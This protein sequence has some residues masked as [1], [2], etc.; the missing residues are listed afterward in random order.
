MAFNKCR[1]CEKKDIQFVCSE[2]NSC[3]HY[4]VMCNTCKNGTRVYFTKEDAFKA[5]NEENK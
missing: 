4:S 2:W 1:F 5:W 3:T